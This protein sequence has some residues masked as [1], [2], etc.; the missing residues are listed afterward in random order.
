MRNFWDQTG[1]LWVKGS[2][3][4]KP[5]GVFCSTASLHGGQETTLISMMFTLL[6]HG[7]IILG[8]PYNVKELSETT[9]GGTPY[10][11]TAVVGNQADQAPTESDLRICEALGSRVTLAAQKLK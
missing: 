9:H 1:G 11:P 4:G 7:M 6:H 3:I 2:L 10:G 5:A 8:V